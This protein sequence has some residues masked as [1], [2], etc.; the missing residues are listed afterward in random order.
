MEPDHIHYGAPAIPI[1]VEGCGGSVGGSVQQGIGG[2]GVTGHMAGEAGQ[3][4]R[5]PGV[6][7]QSLLTAACDSGHMVGG[8]RQGI[9]LLNAW[10]GLE[11]QVSTREKCRGW[12]GK[13][14][15]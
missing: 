1:H 7:R 11:F 9:G 15:S 4:G 5:H 14:K 10:Q 3:A 2:S 8:I 13:G 6:I 12:V